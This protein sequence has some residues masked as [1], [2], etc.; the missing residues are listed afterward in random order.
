MKLHFN[1]GKRL[2]DETETHWRR[3]QTEE[4]RY[5]KLMRTGIWTE[6]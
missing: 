1:K 2:P 5:E 3:Y 6:R 4:A